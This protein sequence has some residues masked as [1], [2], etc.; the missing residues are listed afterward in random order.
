MKSIE[1]NE[2]LQENTLNINRDV[3]SNGGAS[4]ENQLEKQ[5]HKQE[6]HEN[7]QDNNEKII[8]KQ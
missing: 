3:I 5:G 2:N 1:N 4:S 8:G 7:Q 6:N